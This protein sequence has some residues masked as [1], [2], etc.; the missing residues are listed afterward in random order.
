MAPFLMRKGAVRELCVAVHG[1]AAPAFWRC[2]TAGSL[3]D[4]GERRQACAV[5]EQTSIHGTHELRL[6]SEGSNNLAHL[7]PAELL[8]VAL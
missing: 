5:Q 7:V 2:V 4:G 3:V 6:R 8:Q 1:R